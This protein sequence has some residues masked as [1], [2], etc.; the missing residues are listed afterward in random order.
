MM[1]TDIFKIDASWAEKLMKTRVSLLTAPTV[2]IFIVLLFYCVG[3]RTDCV[4]Q[5]LLQEVMQLFAP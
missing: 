1:G 5:K 3:C 2:G 4:P